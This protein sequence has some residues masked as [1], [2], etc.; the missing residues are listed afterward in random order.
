MTEQPVSLAS[1]FLQLEVLSSVHV[2]I[3]VMISSNVCMYAQVQLK[4][5]NVCF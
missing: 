3:L 2:C 4:E 5:N 1:C